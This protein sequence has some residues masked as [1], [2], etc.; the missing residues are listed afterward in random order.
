MPYDRPA[1]PGFIRGLI[2]DALCLIA[3]AVLMAGM[4]I[5]F[6]EIEIRASL[7]EGHYL[8]EPNTSE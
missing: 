7:Y 5:A 3:I 4:V 1:R 2:C 8:G 6:A